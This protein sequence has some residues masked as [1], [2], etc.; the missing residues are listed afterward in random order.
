MFGKGISKLIGYAV[1][2]AIALAAGG[3][4]LSSVVSVVLAFRIG[5]ITP[6]VMVI[7][8]TIGILLVANRVADESP[9]KLILGIIAYAVTGYLA[10][11]TFVI[12]LPYG[13]VYAG[14]AAAI[15]AGVCSFI[16]DP[17]MLS[18]YFQEFTTQM[19]SAGSLKGI[20]KRIVPVGDGDSFTL[21]T[22]HN[23]LILEDGSREKIIQL[24]EDR[25]LLPISLTHYVDCDV[26]FVAETPNHAKLE[27]VLKLLDTLSIKTRGHTSQLLAEAIQM[28]P[29]IDSQNGLRLDNYRFAKDEKSIKE[30]LALAPIRMTV[31]PTT[32]GLRV[33]IPDS[34]APG[35]I[36][37]PLGQGKEIDVLLNRD[38][39]LLE[40]VEKIVETTA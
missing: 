22:Y 17:A 34:D 30:L 31:F 27:Q 38:Y 29:I 13:M 24:M 20:T 14:I 4:L 9:L 28:I 2:G 1:A 23:I 11:V 40:E 16:K 12:V 32:A 25:P 35:L 18:A 5:N 15:A 10:V 21:N 39:T 26:L 33:L 7:A 36:V 8:L 3:E 37:E 6:L 19:Q